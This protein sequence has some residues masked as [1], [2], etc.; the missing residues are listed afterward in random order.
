MENLVCLLR[1][2]CHGSQEEKEELSKI[3][4]HAKKHENTNRSET[5]HY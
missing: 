5:E 3:V 1:V 4:K 2:V